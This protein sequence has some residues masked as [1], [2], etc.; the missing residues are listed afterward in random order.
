[1]EMAGRLDFTVPMASIMSLLSLWTQARVALARGDGE[2][3]RH[4]L[5]RAEFDV[6]T[7]QIAEQGKRFLGAIPARLALA[8]GQL[9]PAL[10]WVETCGLRFDDSPESRLASN[11]YLEYITLARVLLAQGRDPR[12]GSR[13]SQA[14]LLLERLH[15]LT[16]GKAWQGRFIEI[17]MLTA[18]ALQAQGKT[19][20]ALKIL[21]PVLALAEPEGYVRLFADEGPPMAHLLAQ[22]APYTSASPGYIQRLQAALAPLQNASADPAPTA[23]HQPLPDPLSPREREVLSL[24]AEGFSNQQIADHLVISLNTAKRHVK[25]LLA[26]L[27][28][29]NRT[30]A[31]GRARELHLL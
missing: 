13:L 16:V 5:E 25:H 6:A 21:G 29:T 28:V 30:Q 11:G 1:M 27:V 18:L 24:L 26:K 3:A 23:L 15:S 20:R 4:L 9:E 31:V 12:H 19:K 7:S 14:A 10:R 2:K 8:C 17:Q 22:I